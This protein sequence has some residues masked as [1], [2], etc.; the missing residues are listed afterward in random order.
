MDAPE[1]TSPLLMQWK[2]QVKLKIHPPVL[3]ASM[4]PLKLHKSRLMSLLHQL[5]IYAANN[6]GDTAPGPR[7]YSVITYHQSPRSPCV[8][9]T[10][11]FMFP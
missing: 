3:L 2:F 7:N 4:N 8:L 6:Q 9:P 10:Y 1:K 5:V 11:P